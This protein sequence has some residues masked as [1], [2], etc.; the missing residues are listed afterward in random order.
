LRQQHN[1]YRYTFQRNVR[2]LYDHQD[3]AT[4]HPSVLDQL[5]EN[6]RDGWR[7]FWRAVE[8]GLKKA[9]APIVEVPPPSPQ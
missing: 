5:P 6:E 7:A 9:D 3:F 1:R 4:V 2:G 8:A